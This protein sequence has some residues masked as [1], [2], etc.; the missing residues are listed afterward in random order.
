MGEI[1]VL[2]LSNILLAMAGVVV[3]SSPARIE[4]LGAK[5]RIHVLP[6]VTM[7]VLTQ[8]HPFLK[9]SCLLM[10]SLVPSIAYVRPNI[11]RK[12]RGCR[13]VLKLQRHGAENRKPIDLRVLPHLLHSGLFERSDNMVDA[14]AFLLSEISHISFKAA[15]KSE[16]SPL[17]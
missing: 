13:L 7:Q 6:R 17:M 2:L 4:V 3:L 16:P 8:N 15:L 14:V 5:V 9:P 11:P 12:D 10:Y 1:E